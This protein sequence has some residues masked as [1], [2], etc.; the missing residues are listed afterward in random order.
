VGSALMADDEPQALLREMLE[1]GR[2]AA[3][4]R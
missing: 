1:G 4:Q 3:S 2:A